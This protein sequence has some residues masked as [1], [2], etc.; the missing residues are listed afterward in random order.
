MDEYRCQLKIATIESVK[1]MYEEYIRRKQNQL[2]GQKAEVYFNEMNMEQF[3][4]P[5]RST[6]TE[7][8]RRERGDRQDVSSS[9]LATSLD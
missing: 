9:P 2:S 6:S 1:C 3:Y 4:T 7:G 8:I 5:P